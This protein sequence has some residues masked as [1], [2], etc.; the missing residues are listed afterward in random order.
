MA[1][2][3]RPGARASCSS[4]TMRRSKT[5]LVLG[6]ISFTAARA[7]FCCQCGSIPPASVMLARSPAVFEGRV[8]SVKNARRT[9]QS[10]ET[11]TVKEVSLK[12][13]RYWRVRV[14]RRLL[15]I[16]GLS[17]CDYPF[18]PGQSYLVFSEFVDTAVG[19]MTASKCSPTTPM[20]NAESVLR[21]LGL[22]ERPK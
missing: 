1:R 12:V 22:G 3:K 16:V 10:G 14:P 13:E 20:R 18:E 9:L 4:L 11:A 8:Q 7:V 2:P 6:S 19:D 5:A 21:E 17:N 15:L